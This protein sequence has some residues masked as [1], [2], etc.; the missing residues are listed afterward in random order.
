MAITND[1][2]SAL[3][4]P[5]AA[6]WSAGVAFN[7]SN[8]LPLDKW[9]VFQSMAEAIAYAESNAVAYPGQI[10]AVYDN[11]DMVAC[12][13]TEVEGKLV[14]EAIGVVPEGDGV[15]I[16]VID[17]KMSLVGFEAAENN[18]Q[19][20][21]GADGE[22]KWIVPSTDTVDGLQTTVKA[23]QQDIEDIRNELNPVD[24]E[25]NPTGEG[26][27]SDVDKLEEAVGAETVYDEEGNV[28]T[29]A[30]GIYKDIEDI[31]DKIGTE[32]EYGEDGSLTAAATGLYAE[33]ETKA[34]QA[35][36]DAAF[37][38][39]ESD[40][41]DLNQAISDANA[42]IEK[43]ANAEDVYTKQ[44]VNDKIASDISAAIVDANHLSREIVNAFEDI[45]PAAPG[46]EKIIYMVPTGLQADDDKYDEYMVINGVVEKVGSWEVD[47][48]AYA[49][50]A[51]VN[52]ALALKAN[53]ADV[54]ADLALKANAADVEAD[55]ALKANTADV[56][57]DLAKKVD[58]VEG[59]RLMTD[60]EGEKLAAIEPGAEVNVIDTVSSEFSIGDGRELQVNAIEKSKI[61]GLNDDLTTINNDI[62]ELDEA[63]NDINTALDGKVDKVEGSRLI[64]N[65]EAKKLSA[66]VV[67]EDGSV[68]ISGTVGAAKVQELYDN[69]VRIVTNT[70]T[71]EYDGEQK[72]LL[73]IEKGAEVNVI[74]AVSSDFTIG[75]NR[76]LSLNDISISKV[77]NLQEALDGK[78]NAEEGSRLITAAEVAKLEG[79]AESAEKNYISA[80]SAD[81]S[82]V[83]G[84]L[85]LTN[86]YVTTGVYAAEVGDLSKLMHSALGA[87][88]NINEN[89]TLVDEINYI[90]ERLMWIEME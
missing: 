58:A 41:S 70:G 78:V 7:R 66:L 27:V 49:K 71:A 3:N 85:S 25:G 43:K 77:T 32:A 15:T 88:G 57:A 5:K 34:N 50:T 1:F 30:T 90:N 23:L 22:L 63:V 12:V 76:T 83:D 69:V 65:D 39:V 16:E 84:T 81:F 86:S 2:F 79:I 8:P 29:P 44:E 46:A 20:V 89:S 38:E 87:D 14:P 10:I 55:L 26:L 67:E 48:S 52:N 80:V 68:A 60:A 24:E 11:N 61:T 56:E 31:E 6:M 74:D 37:D 19:L 54:E 64:T 75:E 45:D 82:V 62:A 59:S 18:A 36:V 28:V 17:G 35:D 9:S 53:T 13:L 33:L 51:D 72:E 42:E 4:D 73:G 47:L 21:K 40:I